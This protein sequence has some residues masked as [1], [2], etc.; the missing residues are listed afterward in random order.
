M[1]YIIS[2]D[3]IIST[4][5][6]ENIRKKSKGFS[7]IFRTTILDNEF[8]ASKNDN[9]MKKQSPKEAGDNY[10]KSG[11][12]PDDQLK[13]TEFEDENSEEIKN[14]E[15]ISENDL[16][17]IENYNMLETA[18]VLA[19]NSQEF[20]GKIPEY[21]Q[22]DNKQKT[23]TYSKNESAKALSIEVV[24]Q[25][26]EEPETEI[27]SLG[28]S[29]D[30]NEVVKLENVVSS[31]ENPWIITNKGGIVTLDETAIKSY[32]DPSD[33][34]TQKYNEKNESSTVITK[35]DYTKQ[36]DEDNTVSKSMAV[37]YRYYE[38]PIETNSSKY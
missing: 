15:Q 5:Y 13:L 19:E 30:N 23:D 37:E 29:T 17:T 38:Y 24:L 35:T 25:K 34:S 33:Q 9:D 7:L 1:A 8:L 26:N 4:C 20:I 2:M 16:R 21:F 27:N 10:A 12:F 11:I 36:G 14:R 32:R 6:K 31:A 3:L 22:N 28:N 18:S